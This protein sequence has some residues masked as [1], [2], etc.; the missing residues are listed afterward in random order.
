MQ[1]SLEDIA[2]SPLK[3]SP[4]EES[5][6]RRQY[7][8]NVVTN[9]LVDTS[10]GII[11]FAPPMALIEYA[12]GM[13]T[14]EV[15]KARAFAAGSH[16]LITRPYGKFREW[17]AKYWGADAESSHLKK[18]VVDTSALIMIATPLYAT[19][20]S[21]AGASLKEGSIALPIGITFGV[22]SGR[23]FGWWMDKWR[24]LWKKKPLLSK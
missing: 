8:R 2:E 6:S 9:Y 18:F 17:W 13:D 10:A 3:Q 19:A 24:K 22:F 15:L 14:P 16:M 11:Y 23:P 21:V 20:L 5:I 4:R 7:L 1:E 12:A